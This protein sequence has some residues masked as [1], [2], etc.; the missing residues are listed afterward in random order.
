MLPYLAEEHGSAS[1]EQIFRESILL[2]P[3]L[4]VAIL[5]LRQG[6]SARRSLRIVSRSAGSVNRL[7]FPHRISL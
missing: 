3:M 1:E 4:C 6:R 5:D 2:F 7:A